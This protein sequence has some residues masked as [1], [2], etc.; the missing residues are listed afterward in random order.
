MCHRERDHQTYFVEPVSNVAF[1]RFQADPHATIRFK[2]N[3]QVIAVSQIEQIIS[4]IY[5]C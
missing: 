2:D 1:V 4:A 3:R 5:V